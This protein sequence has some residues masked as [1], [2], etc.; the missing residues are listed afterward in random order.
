MIKKNTVIIL[1]AGAS[2]PY[3]YPLGSGLKTSILQVANLNSN[4]LNNKYQQS[5]SAHNVS[6]NL[7]LT[8]YGADA[9]L[10]YLILN[11]NFDPNDL[12]NFYLDFM[13]SSK[14]SIDTFLE[15]RQ[16]L[17]NIG[18]IF[19]AYSIFQ[20]ENRNNLFNNDVH[21]WYKYLM[22]E[23]SSSWENLSKNKLGIITYNYDRS[24]E[25][26]M[27]SDLKHTYRKTLLESIQKINETIM[28]KH[29]HGMIAD[30]PTDNN[31]QYGSPIMS[32]DIEDA[33][34][35]LH[36]IIEEEEV[37]KAYVDI[38]RMLTEAEIVFIFG[39]GFDNRNLERLDLAK[40]AK[41]ALIFATRTGLSDLEVK[42][43]NS[44]LD[45]KIL[46]SKDETHDIVQFLRREVN[47]NGDYSDE[48]IKFNSELRKRKF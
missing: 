13:G 26:F 4:A 28:I 23:I 25:T 11:K 30:A 14:P 41:N 22:N 24:L 35:K 19:I 27:T 33:I 15:C 5:K 42:K 36:V 7:N 40:N 17:L 45:Y 8:Q 21:N 48:T 34:K 39:F 2:S 12:R 31:K 18:K 29:V 3:K 47:L 20:C 9:L 37:R 38:H 16:E 44:K 32:L 46:F 1:G 6:S 43:I 10:D